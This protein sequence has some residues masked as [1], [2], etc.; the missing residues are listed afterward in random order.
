MVEH[1]LP[2]LGARVR[3]PSPAPVSRRLAPWWWDYLLILG[4]LLPVFL[5]GLS[6]ILGWIDLTPVWTDQNASDVGI[7]TLT[8]FPYLAGRAR[9]VVTFPIARV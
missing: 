2:K 5:V 3:F 8:V 6:Q 1:E 4:W 7:T 9:F